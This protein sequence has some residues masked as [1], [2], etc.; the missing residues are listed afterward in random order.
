VLSVIR[1][2]DLLIR[3]LI[4][5]IPIESCLKRHTIGSRYFVSP[6][7]RGLFLLPRGKRRR[8]RWR[9]KGGT[10]AMLS[11]RGAG[12]SIALLR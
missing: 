8:S 2:W 1:H 6:L 10:R 11:S 4:G 3:N 5:R 12:I 7:R 9:I